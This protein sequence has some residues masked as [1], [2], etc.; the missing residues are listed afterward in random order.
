MVGTP[1]QPGRAHGVGLHDRARFGHLV[2]IEIDEGLAG[3]DVAHR[4][5]P[6]GVGVLRL[7]HHGVGGGVEAVPV[8][9]RGW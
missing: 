8:R 4:D 2:G 5:L 7:V 9:G 6:A 1:L 3:V